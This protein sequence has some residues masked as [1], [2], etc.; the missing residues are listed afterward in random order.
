M[1]LQPIDKTIYRRRLN[2]L[3]AISIGTLLVGALAL[4]A[5]F[6]AV[7]SYPGN[8]NFSL[9]LMAVVVSVAAIITLLSLNKHHPRLT[10]V[11]Y[12][13]RLKMELNVINAK[14]RFV[15]SAAEKDQTNALIILQ[16]F[17]AG[18]R[19]LWTLDDN[20][21]SMDSLQIKEADLEQQLSRLQ[22][23]IDETSYHRAL[24]NELD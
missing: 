2:Q 19:Q 23:S 8:N 4:S 24:L 16:F 17:Y 15:T 9:N 1:Q 14:M 3:I 13:W 18:S 12:V 5:L 20:T 22:L 6:I 21:I 7:F 10:E 11:Y